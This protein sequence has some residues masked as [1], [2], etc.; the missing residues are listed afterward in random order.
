MRAR[1]QLKHDGRAIIVVP[2]LPRLYGSVD[3]L[4]GHFRR[5]TRRELIAVANAAG[6]E[7]ESIRY[8]NP[9]AILPYWLLYRVVGV[10]SVSSGQ[11]GFYDRAIVPLAY[12]IIGLFGGKIPGINLIAILKNPQ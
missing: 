6:F 9:L 8:F 4:S 7:V 3:S 11:L 5:F 1:K 12:K 10:K 2:S